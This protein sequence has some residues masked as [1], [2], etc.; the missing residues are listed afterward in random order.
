MYEHE[1]LGFIHLYGLCI[2]IGALLALA[3]LHYYCK[4]RHYDTRFID[5]IETTALFAIMG[6]FIG[7]VLLQA[8]YNFNA[9][10]SSIPFFKRWVQAFEKGGITFLGGLLGGAIT[11]LIVYFIRRKKYTQK[12]SDILPVVPGAICIAHGFGRIGCF[13]A[14]CC[15]GRQVD[16][17]WEWI[18]Q[19]YPVGS[20]TY[21]D[22]VSKYG[23]NVLVYPT[24]LLEAAFL[25]ILGGI[26]LYLAFKRNSKYTF[27]IYLVAYGIYRFLN[28]F[29]RGD[30]RGEIF[31]GALS[32]SQYFSLALVVGGIVAFFLFKKYIHVQSMSEVLEID[33]N[34]VAPVNEKHTQSWKEFLFGKKEE[35][36][37]VEEDL[38]KGEGNPVINDKE[39]EIS[40]K[41]EVT[42]DEVASPKDEENKK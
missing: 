9:L 11:F 39:K 30:Y 22:I 33:K 13:F 6:G 8:V 41:C 29:L 10:D 2:A 16:A 20:S 28:E 23:S 42:S 40:S 34:Y 7:A 19:R 14:G 21:N 1:I 38:I 3:L 4:K 25:L 37:H 5:F 26:L 35:Q 15:Y 27:P 18:G 17:G 12:V 24:Q 31:G 36:I 32:P